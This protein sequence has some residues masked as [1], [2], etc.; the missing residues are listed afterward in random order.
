MM[1]EGNNTSSTYYAQ[2]QSQP[3]TSTATVPAKNQNARRAF[4]A[5]DVAISLGQFVT[6][7]A[8]AISQCTIM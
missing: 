6:N 1:L 5:L 7:A 8:S 3:S 4:K 2:T